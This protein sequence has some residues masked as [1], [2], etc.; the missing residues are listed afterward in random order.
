MREF[1]EG[2]GESQHPRSAGFFNKAKRFW[3]DITSSEEPDER[4]AR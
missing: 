2:C 1:A 3:D 4:V